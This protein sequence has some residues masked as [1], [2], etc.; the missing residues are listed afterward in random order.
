MYLATLKLQN[1]RNYEKLTTRFGD[2]TTILT[3]ANAAGKT[4]LLEAIRFLS[5]FKSWRAARSRDLINWKTKVAR[6]EGEIKEAGQT[7]KIAASLQQ[8]QAELPTKRI[9]ALNG[10][11]VPTRAAVGAFLTVLFSPDDVWLVA[12]A[13][14][15]RRH[16]LDTV[17]GQ[18][19]PRYYESLQRYSQALEQRNFLIFTSVK[20]PD[21]RAQAE[22]WEIQMALEG[23]RLIKE[24]SAFIEMINQR[25][26]ADYREISQDDSRLKINY[27]PALDNPGVET[28]VGGMELQRWLQNGWRKNWARD[29]NTRQTNFGPHRDD[30]IF[31]LD[32]RPLASSGSRGEWRSAVLALKLGEQKFIEQRTKKQPVLLLDDIFSELDATRRATL[33]RRISVAQCFLTVTDLTT[34]NRQFSDQAQVFTVTGGKLKASHE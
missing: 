23:S 12:A 4:N 34:L 11:R 15:E 17:L 6:V 7:R 25:L 32:G 14:K 8:D 2:R 9:T 20:T 13:P 27:Q 10:A 21:L 28:L 1:F 29:L 22:S 19:S 16:Y 3:G 30:F 24:R 26:A 31:T 33:A 18:I 5:L